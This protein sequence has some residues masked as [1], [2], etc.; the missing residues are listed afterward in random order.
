MRFFPACVLLGACLV[1]G[2]IARADAVADALGDARRQAAAGQSE[3]ALATIDKALGA[4]PQD[5]QL[6]FQRGVLLADLGRHEAA[7][8][9]FLALNQE[10]PELPD[11]LN[12]LAVL[13]AAQG[14]LERARVALE[15]ALRNQPGHR[16]ARENLGDVY[17]RMALRLWQSL[18][19]GTQVEPTLARKL[20]LARQ[21]VSVQPG[22]P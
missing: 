3:V 2:G 4:K 19:A 22:S 10:F 20:A 9:V 17:A 18:A 5:A 21:L 11:P 1:V 15:A 14:D 16:A 13:H 8:Q 12:N 7:M 6:R